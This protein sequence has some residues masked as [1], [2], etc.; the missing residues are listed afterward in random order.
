M[1]LGL[2]LEEAEEII[3][4]INLYLGNYTFVNPLEQIKELIAIVNVQTWTIMRMECMIPKDRMDKYNEILKV[5]DKYY[6]LNKIVMN[7]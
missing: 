6:K 1:G 3:G 4:S 2:T 7:L 5:R